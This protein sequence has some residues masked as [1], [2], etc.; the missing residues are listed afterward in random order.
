MT[1]FYYTDHSQKGDPLLFVIETDSMTSA[2]KAMK[3]QTGIDPMK[4]GHIG[5]E[6]VFDKNLEIYDEEPY[7][8]L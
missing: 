1:I 8:L 5:C 4:T 3:E 7:V 2:D 6:P